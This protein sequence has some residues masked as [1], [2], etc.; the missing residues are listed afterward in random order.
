MKKLLLPIAILAC[1]AM[2]CSAKAQPLQLRWKLTTGDQFESIDRQESV[3]DTR[4]EKR[5]TKIISSVELK[6]SWR[7][8]S[9]TNDVAT[10]EQTIDGISINVQNPA[11]S[12]KS[13]AVDTSSKTRPNKSS[14]SLLKQIQPVIGLKLEFE[15]SQRG[16]IQSV[17]LPQASQTKLDSLADDHPV[18]AILNVDRLSQT[19]VQASIEF[20]ESEIE[21]GK[22]WRSGDGTT[23]T[24]SGRKNI[25]GQ[26]V[27]VLK[28]AS[29]GTNLGELHFDATAGN[30][31]AC[32]QR[33]NTSNSREYRDMA[34]DTSVETTSTIH[35]QR[36]DAPTSN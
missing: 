34:V 14:R 35:L 17:R 27:E 5:D 23:V 30:T 21:S 16:A 28:L 20:P 32:R 9:V 18:K 19:L 1:I 4:V 3:I 29:G 15:L 7:V 13:V 11:N 2:A 25:D 6:S 26:Q 12:T 36:I 33:N 24:Y 10:I 22:Q 31:I 8:T